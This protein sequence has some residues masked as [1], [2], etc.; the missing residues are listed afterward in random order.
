MS[1]RTS[2]DQTL[3]SLHAPENSGP[4]RRQQLK[5][6]EPDQEDRRIE[7]YGPVGRTDSDRYSPLPAAEEPPRVD[8]EGIDLDRRCV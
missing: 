3:A 1:P 6:N 8:V 2:G 5:R 7:G 4:L